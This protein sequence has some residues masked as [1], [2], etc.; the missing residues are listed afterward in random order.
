MKTDK[1]SDNNMYDKEDFQVYFLVVTE[2]LPNMSL[3][4]H[5]EI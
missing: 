5:P 3:P 1:I 4:V 2:F